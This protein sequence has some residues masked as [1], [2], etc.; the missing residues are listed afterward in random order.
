MATPYQAPKK[1]LAPLTNAGDI[2]GGGVAP[3]GQQF[4]DQKGTTDFV[5][6]D[7]LLSANA[8]KGQAMLDNATSN[9]VDTTADFSDVNAINNYD[10]NAHL[11]SDTTSKST[12]AH[13]EEK[14]NFGNTTS[15][16]T[17]SITPTTT[18]KYDGLSTAD[19]DAKKANIDA[20]RGKFGD[21][22]NTFAD[23]PKGVELRQVAQQKAVA[24]IPTYSAQQGAFDSFLTENEGNKQDANGQSS[25]GNRRDNITKL[26]SKFDGID[27]RTS[28]VKTDISTAQG[29]VGNLTGNVVS[30]DGEKK[31]T[32]A[33]NPAESSSATASAPSKPAVV[34]APQDEPER[35]RNMDGT[36]TTLNPDGGRTVTY[37]N[38]LTQTYNSSGE[39][40]NTYDPNGATI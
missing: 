16:D 10:P 19:I 38:G 17:T 9:Q 31:T 11:S 3:E 30:T 35:A 18:T 7:K 34:Y 25:I 24:K 8:G 13:K 15:W 32:Y 28:K 33:A 4:S 27:D 29:K 40:V 2:A 36:R 14:D 12:T 5:N 23:S 6:A 39:L 20:L 26:M 37:A 22:G 21:L 1:N